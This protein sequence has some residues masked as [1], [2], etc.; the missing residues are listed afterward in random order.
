MW[1]GEY[2]PPS[3]PLAVEGG[4]RAQSKGGAFGQSWWAKRW[5]VQ[6]RAG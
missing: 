4:I 6:A 2:F 1:Y 3:K 5:I